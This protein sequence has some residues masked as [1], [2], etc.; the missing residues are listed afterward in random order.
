MPSISSNLQVMNLTISENQTWPVVQVFARL[1]LSG[2]LTLSGL[3]G[4]TESEPN[5]SQS[6]GNTLTFDAN[7]RCSV[8]VAK[9]YPRTDSDFFKVTV[10]YSAGP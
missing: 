7:F 10:P 9:I 3:A 1:V 5:D 6:S 8:S 4:I 2:L